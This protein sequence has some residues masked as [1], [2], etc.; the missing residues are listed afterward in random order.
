[1]RRVGLILILIIAVNFSYCQYHYDF[2]QNC[3]DAYSAII[4][5][6]FD[7][8][9]N[10]IEKEKSTNPE[11]NIPYMLENYIHFLTIFIAEEEDEFE[12]LSKL[13]DDIISRL[14][15]GDKKSPYYRYCLSQVYLQWAFA[16]SKF[17]E[18]VTA[19]FEINKAYRQLEANNEEF[20][21]FLPNLINLG[22]LHTLIGTVP[23]NYNWIKKLVGVEGTI[24]QGVGEILTVLNESISNEEY[25]MYKTECLFYLSFIQMNLMTNKQ[26]ALDYIKM[27]EDDSCSMQNPLAI[28]AIS[29][30]YMDNSKNDEAIELLLSKPTGE[31]YFPFYYLD[32]LT[33]LAKLHRL[34]DDA[35]NYL[36]I[37]VNNYK[38]IN[39]IK[40][41]YQ[42]IAWYYI[43]NCNK[44]KY[45][46]YINKIKQY[47]N[48]IADADEQ[49]EREAENGEE[50]NIYLLRA[51]LLFDGGYYEKALSAIT[52][53]TETG[54][55]RNTK[56]S[57]EFYYRIGRIYHEWDKV[58]NSIS[59]YKKT[60]ENGAESEY[61]F[62][63]NSA[64]KLGIIYESKG[65]Y[66]N[67]E[68]YYEEAQSME[69][70]EYRNSINQK[71]KAGLHRIENRE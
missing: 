38:G 70:K 32:Y 4:S 1:M 61:Y 6:K 41:A 68:F 48:S 53:E 66:E 24:D 57:L 60:V 2:N 59:F 35:V 45:T 30:I 47:G 56:D 14:K 10:L 8:G 19:T 44:E 22:L 3:K 50:P 23:N 13:K 58:D 27:I 55:L 26:K 51:R 63:A 25:S 36:F 29:R 52:G 37:Y 18:Y 12:K 21:D 40:D 17:K 69:N 62:A 43:V 67:A 28:Y 54:F 5:L 20:P 49:A 9:K 39:Y 65:D 64:L 15:K 46:E 33:G 34:D 31:E 11:N 42:K 16:R 71:A 7:E